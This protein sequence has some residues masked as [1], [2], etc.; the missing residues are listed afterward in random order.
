MIGARLNYSTRRATRE[1][2]REEEPQGYGIGSL[3]K[4]TG[5]LLTP[6]ASAQTLREKGAEEK[7]SEHAAPIYPIEVDRP[8]QR[9]SRTITPM[10]HRREARFNTMSHIKRRWSQR[11]VTWQH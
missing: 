11:T 7:H 4:G 3:R 2:E 6:C 5:S 9:V 10:L 1:R 8:A